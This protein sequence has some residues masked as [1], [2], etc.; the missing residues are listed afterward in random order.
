M[1]RH[2]AML[3]FQ[4]PALL[5]KKFCQEHGIP[6][7]EAEQCFEETKKFLTLCATNQG[8][9]YSP[10]KVVDEMWH[11]FILHTRDYFEFCNHLGGFIHHQPAAKRQPR[12]YEKT[13]RDLR[14]LFGGLNEKYWG[15]KKTSSVDCSDCSSTCDCCA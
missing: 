13:R 5:I 6:K 9:N 8:I 3:T 15:D 12:S 10:S 7:S 11:Q 4:P 2:R 1:E 14:K